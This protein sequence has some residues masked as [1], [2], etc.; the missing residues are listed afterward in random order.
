MTV[1]ISNRID[2]LENLK[3]KANEFKRQL[4][5]SV[6]ISICSGTGCMAYS[7]DVIY[8]GLQKEIEKSSSKTAKKII[9][10]RTGCHGYCERGPIVV[11]YPQ[12]ICYLGVRE[13]D[14]PEIVEKTINGEIVESLL[15]KDGEGNPIIKETDIP[16]YKF[17]ER[18]VLGNNSKIDP[19]SID[20][21]IRVGGYQSLAK[22]LRQMSADKVL[23]EMK[24]A[25]L[26]GRGGGGF[27]AGI[28]WETT[29]KAPGEPKYVIVNADEGDPGAY[30]D[31]SILEGN[32]HSILEGLIIGAFAIGSN[33]GFV[34]VRQ[35]YPQAVKNIKKAI[36]QA[37]E[38]G[39]LGKNILDSEFDF[40]VEVHR[41]AGAFV[42]GESS[43]LTAAIEGSAGEP[44]LKY[45]RTA[46]SGLWGKPTNLNNVETWANVPLIIKNGADWFKSIGTKNSSGTK[47]FSLVGKVNNTGL[48]EVPMG[49]T[50]RDIIYK[51]GGGIKD[52]KKF[53]AVQTGGPSGGVIPEKLIDLPVDFDE[54]T[55]A[56]SMMGSGGM[57]VMDESDCMVNVAHYFLKFLADE[58]CGKCVPCREGLRQMIYIY[59]RI[60]EGKGREVDLTL[61][62]DLSLLLKEASLCA[63]G[64]TAPNIVLTTLK[65]FKEEYEA[66]IYY[67]I[68]PAK[69]CIPLIS[70]VIDENKCAGC[71]SC[72]KACPVDAIRGESKKPH[73]IDSEICIKCGSCIE[74]CP[75]KYSAVEKKTGLVLEKVKQK[76]EMKGGMDFSK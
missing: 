59:E 12:E 14:I 48:V 17:Q 35:E 64:T 13:K 16:F 51:I 60:M 9:L 42:S 7:S 37:K 26:R 56:G 2:S 18:I 67:N 38:Y 72:V 66:H 40:D 63:L 36:E 47:I 70:Y 34:Y 68:C 27:P 74:A 1:K 43:A 33:K 30:M 41:G 62:A 28:K 11:I 75:E 71:G 54:L 6:V 53:K 8:C 55:K 45:I 31:R 44:R 65:Y 4:D 23:K 69:V 5:D 21:Y 46:V 10:R 58:S 20:D 19:E 39:F 49:I 73:I 52:G 25:N 22:A 29:K 76:K 3:G 61:L 57:V 24:D 50:L 32:P 15:Y